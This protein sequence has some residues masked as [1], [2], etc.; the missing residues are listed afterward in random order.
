MCMRACA[1]RCV[2]W[3]CEWVLRSLCMYVA[4]A[5]VCSVTAAAF[6]PTHSIVGVR[7]QKMGVSACVGV[8]EFIHTQKH[9]YIRVHTHTHLD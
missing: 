5:C 7:D 4:S 2:F 8:F 1:G 3:K 6:T 9:T